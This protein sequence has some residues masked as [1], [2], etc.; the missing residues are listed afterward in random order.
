MASD[1]MP[2]KRKGRKPLVAKRVDVALA[3]STL[4]G[5]SL[6]GADLFPSVDGDFYVVSVKGNWTIKDQTAGEGPIIV[7]FA[8]GDYTDAEI[9]E[10]YEVTG[11][12]IR[13]DKI[14]NE[15]A[16]RRCRESGA[17]QCKD[18]QP[19]TLN[20]GNPQNTPMRFVIEDGQ[21]IKFWAYNDS[22]ATLTTGAIV[23]FRGK[24]FGRYI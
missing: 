14:A 6:L 8:H 21:N 13:G 10:W 7:G 12:F 18:Q 24:V 19:E 3:L 5:A 20:D 9:E 4:G 11:E 1:L 23:E 22:G 15:R 2:K 16:R 17:F